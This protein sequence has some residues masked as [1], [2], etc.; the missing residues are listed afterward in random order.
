M[1]MRKQILIGVALLAALGY[2]LAECRGEGDWFIFLSASNDIFNGVDVYNKHYVD[3][4]HYFYSIFFGILLKP[5]TLL[6]LQ[7][8]RFIWL[9]VNAFF[10]FRIFKICVSFFD[11]GNFSPRK[12]MLLVL[13]PFV[14]CLRFTLENFH[15]AQLTTLMLYLSLEGSYLI[16]EKNK[17]YGAVLI[18]LGINIKLFPLVLVPLLLYRK[19]FAAAALVLLFTAAFYLVPALFIG[20]QQN[21]FLLKQW[22]ALVNPA[23]SIHVLDVEE[24]TFHGLSTLFSTLF[25]A[26]DKVPDVYQLALKR[27]IA[28]ISLETLGWLITIA[29]LALAAFTLY[30]LRTLPFRKAANKLHAFYDLSYILL[31]VPLIFPHQQTYA[32]LFLLPAAFCITHLLLTEHTFVRSVK[33]KI[34]ISVFVL[35]YLVCNLKLLLGA[36]NDYYQHYKIVTYGA[37]LMIPLLAAAFKIKRKNLS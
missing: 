36:F 16:F 26:H 7:V 13:L 10:L 11:T 18:A 24:R 14:F 6:P 5:F 12:K 28:D 31:I 22:F 37:L 23:N 20:W 1:K 35:C 25:V 33:G 4:Y 29:R 15:L 34:F 21:M 2:I 30:F 32:F 9:S 19:K 3:G 8:S 27:N 17:W